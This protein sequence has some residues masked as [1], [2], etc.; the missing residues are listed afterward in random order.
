[1]LR[2][3]KNKVK[4]ENEDKRLANMKKNIKSLKI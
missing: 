3:K 2:P 1:M 4:R